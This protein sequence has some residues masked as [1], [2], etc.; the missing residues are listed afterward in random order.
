[1]LY[2]II[3]ALL[4]I[5]ACTASS[6]LQIRDPCD[7][8]H[9]LCF[10][11]EGE[12][13]E[14][15]AIGKGIRDLLHDLSSSVKSPWTKQRDLKEVEGS[16][17]E[18]APSEDLCCKSGSIR[19]RGQNLVATVLTGNAGF[20]GDGCYSLR[21]RRAPFCYV[22]IYELQPSS[23][24]LFLNLFLRTRTIPTSGFPAA[25]LGILTPADTSQQMATGQI[26]T[27]E[28]TFSRM[29]QLATFTTTADHQRIEALQPFHSRQ[30]S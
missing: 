8:L 24:V 1:M 18:R 26:Y 6:R 30:N 7:D 17:V 19:Q 13:Y 9:Y 14:T 3:L 11:P 21:K 15:P 2:S 4:T 23:F 29:A 25:L 20:F 10:P 5:N 16:L 27:M 22:S 12:E 28:T